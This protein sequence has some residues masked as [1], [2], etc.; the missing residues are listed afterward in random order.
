MQYG[1]QAEGSGPEPVA[2]APWDVLSPDVVEPPNVSSA[3]AVGAHAVSAT[4]PTST[5]SSTRMIDAS[6]LR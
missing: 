5:Q 3:A 6:G 1:R 2:I 4:R